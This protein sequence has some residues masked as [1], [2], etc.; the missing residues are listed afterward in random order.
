MADPVTHARS[1]SE[2]GE[3]DSAA[4]RQLIELGALLRRARQGR[5]TL[6]K[7]SARSGVS[8]GLISQIERGMGNPSFVTLSKL[9][10]A[11]EIPVSSFFSED[12]LHDRTLVRKRHRRQLAL[13]DGLVFELLT[14][15]VDRSL[16]LTLV[17]LPLGWTNESR[18]FTHDGEESVFLI[19][20]EIDIHIGD[21]EY[22]L[23]E[24]DTVTFDATRDHWMHN[25]GTV[26]AVVLTAMTPPS[27]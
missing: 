7:L 21:D 18:P 3:H 24:G 25:V 13:D 4:R 22:R 8:V 6:E 26:E 17:S 14:P 16:A 5:F 20:G 15:D 1:E 12:P 2:V 27:F 11:L 10:Y 19:T 9:A 23:Q